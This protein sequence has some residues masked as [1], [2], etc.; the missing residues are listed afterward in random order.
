M[1]AE[2]E[3]MHRDLSPGLR[4]GTF[5]PEEPADASHKVTSPHLRRVDGA[6]WES[7]QGGHVCVSAL[8]SLLSSWAIMD[9]PDDLRTNQRA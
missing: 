6:G 4:A 3:G 5:S 7:I 8:N 1:L 2:G 9:A